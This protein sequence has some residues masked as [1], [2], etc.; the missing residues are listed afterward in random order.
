MVF[1]G[2]Y[3]QLARRLLSPTATVRALLETSPKKSSLRLMRRNSGPSC[4]TAFRFWG[5]ATCEMFG[6]SSV[7]NY[8]RVS[9]IGSGL[10]TTFR[11]CTIP[12]L[13]KASIK[14]TSDG[15]PRRR[16]VVHH[17]NRRRPKS[18]LGQSLHIRGV[19]SMSA[20]PP[21]ATELLH[22]GNRRDGQ[23]QT[24]FAVGQGSD[25]IKHVRGLIF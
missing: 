4:A 12:A 15:L 1:T 9:D 14:S 6:V 16:A 13:A 21:E 20:M 23:E 11:T 8:H 2:Q 22:C 24:C 18:P 5:G 10:K 7:G 3:P 25:F 17:S 19:R